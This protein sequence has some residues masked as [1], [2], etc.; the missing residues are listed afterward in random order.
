VTAGT[1]HVTPNSTHNGRRPVAGRI[2]SGRFVKEGETLAHFYSPPKQSP[3]N[4]FYLSVGRPI[5]ARL[6]NMGGPDLRV[7][8]DDKSTATVSSLVPSG[9]G[10]WEFTIT[11]VKPGCSLI[12]AKNADGNQWAMTQAVVRPQPKPVVDNPNSVDWTVG[13]YPSQLVTD[14]MDAR[15]NAD[16]VLNLHLALVQVAPGKCKDHDDVEWNALERPDKAWMYFTR[17]VQRDG[18]AFWDNRFWLRTPPEYGPFVTSVGTA[19]YRCNVRCRFKLELVPEDLADQVVRVAYLDTS[20]GA[21]DISQFR[22]EMALYSQQDISFRP[23]GLDTHR[24][25]HWQKTICHEIGDS[26]GLEHIGILIPERAT[27]CPKDPQYCYGEFDAERNNIMGRG[28]VVTP[29]VAR[30]WLQRIALHTGIKPE[31]WTASM[32]P[33][34]PVKL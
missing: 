19:S 25:I 23:A 14:K 24:R 27:F 22:S 28:M 26:L 31:D 18:Q 29:V 9:N 12:R 4:F 5:K 34:P 32:V 15:T 2:T 6:W 8:S 33:L 16:L 1:G 10:L 17:M 20:R 11:G 13:N 21:K 7:D 30:P 3:I